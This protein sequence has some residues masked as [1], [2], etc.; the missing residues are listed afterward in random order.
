MS[1]YDIAIIGGGPAGYNAAANATA[2]GLKVVLFEHNTLG[3]VCLNE[4]CIPTKTLLHSANL[5]DEIRE[6]KAFGIHIEGA[7]SASYAEIASRKDKVVKTLTSGVAYKLKSAGVTV[8]NETAL[9]DGEEG[10]AI[11]IRAGKETYLVSFVLLATG[12]STVIPPIPGL[13]EVAYWTSRE[14]LAAKTLPQDITII[15]GGVIGMEFA[16]IYSSLGVPVQVVEM[17]PEILGAMDKETSAMLRK[18]YASRG[19]K[20][21]LG[22][23]VVSVSKEGVTIEAKNRKTELLPASQVLLS[24]GRKPETDGLRLETLGIEMNRSAVVVNRYMQTSHPRVYAAGDI[25]GFSLLAHTAI[26]E[27]EVA[28][29]HIVGTEDDPMRYDAIPGVVYTHPEIAGVGATEEQLKAEG[30]YYR[31]LKLPMAYAGR[32]VVEHEKAGGLCKILVDENETILGCH[33]LGNPASELIL[34]AG[35]AIADGTRVEEFR[36]HVF[37]HPTV[38]EIIHEVLFS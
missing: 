29:N 15:G 7:V 25:T 6:S 8:V 26:R 13:S 28:I 30:R 1:N 12:S 17:A 10:E 22:A 33:I 21:H 11:R 36:R 38:G 23:K 18:E 27:G 31:V 16:G 19:V 37:P 5:L 20:F 4:G 2:N 24:V 3:G 14:A 32:Y 35:I 9:L 34:L